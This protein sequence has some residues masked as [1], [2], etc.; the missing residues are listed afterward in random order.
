LS[1]IVK[2]MRSSWLNKKRSARTGSNAKIN[3]IYDPAIA[4][5][6]SAVKCR[7]VVAS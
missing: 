1:G 7:A 6:A 3:R 5:G 2:S 4:A